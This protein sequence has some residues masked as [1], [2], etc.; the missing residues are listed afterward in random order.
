MSP[1]TRKTIM[2]VM[3][4]YLKRGIPYRKKQMRRLLAILDD[5]F[6]H[7]PNVGEALEKIGRRQ[8]IGYW[9]RTRLESD[10]VRFEKYQI[11]SLFYGNAG[12]KGRVPKPR[13]KSTLRNKA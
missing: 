3:S 4:S 13:V 5:I 1:Y 6:L 9:E 12:L 10:S 8:I 7:E 11:L 2:A